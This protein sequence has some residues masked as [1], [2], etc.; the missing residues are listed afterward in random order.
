[1]TIANI[2]T[3][4]VVLTKIPPLKF[5]PSGKSILR[6]FETPSMINFRLRSFLGV[7]ARADVL[8]FLL[9]EEKEDFV[10]SDLIE[11]GYSKR[12]LAVILNDLAA[13]GVLSESQVRNQLRYTFVRRDQFIKLLGD[14]PKTWFTGI[15]F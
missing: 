1:M 15:G 14:I 6:N 12:Q 5:Q 9:T 7:N 2:R 11:T 10:A 4:W 8:A 3:K 13:A